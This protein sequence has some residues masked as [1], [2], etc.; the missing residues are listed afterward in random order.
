MKEKLKKIYRKIR[1]IYRKIY[2]YGNKYKCNICSSKVRLMKPHGIKHEIFEKNTIIE[3]GYRENCTCPVCKSKDR[4]RMVY[5]Y[6]EKYTNVFVGN[7]P[8]N[9]EKEDLKK[10]L[11]LV[12]PVKSLEIKQDEYYDG[13]IQKG[14]ATYVVD[15]TDIQFPDN[16]FDYIICNQ[17]LEHIPDEKKAINE[18]KRVI[19][20]NGKIIIT[21]P[22]CV[23]NEKTFEDP[24]ITDSKERLANFCQED[25]VRLYGRDFKK[26]LEK[27][28]FEV[29]EWRVDEHVIEQVIEEYSFSKGGLIYIATKKS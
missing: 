16:K 8:Y 18:L 12:G 15:I 29:E 4:I 13:D 7:I 1:G 21:V 27:F 24:N 25:H 26:R 20:P 23:S 3:A 6:L 19:K 2:Y 5:Y 28:G 14:R 11:S 10:T 17:V 9:D 22:I